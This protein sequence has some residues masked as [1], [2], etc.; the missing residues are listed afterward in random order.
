M[1]NPTTPHHVFCLFLSLMLTV[2]VPL[3]G[4]TDSLVFKNGDVMVGELK[5]M[6]RGVAIVST[7]YSDTDFK[8]SWLEV[9]RVHAKKS[10]VVTTSDDRQYFG[11][12]HS[13]SDGKVSVRT[14]QGDTVESTIDNVV[15]L[16]PVEGTF[17]EKLSATI[18]VGFSLTKA[19]DLRQFTVGGAI[20][21]NEQKWSTDIV[22][23]FLNSTQDNVD[24]IRRNEGTLNY[25]NNL[26][27]TWYAMATLSALTNTEQKLD[28]RFSTQLVGARYLMRTN[29]GY[30]GVKA[31]VSRNFEKYS[32]ATGDRNTWEGVLGA[33]LNLYNAGDLSLVTTAASYPSFTESGRWRVDISCDG[34]YDLPLD[35]YIK[36]GV[37]FN[38]DNRPAAGASQSDYV[39]QTGFG[40]EW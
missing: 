9:R 31:G 34:K 11:I 20:G 25:R 24:P 19:N 38:Y 17:L 28:L 1:N 4:Q 8:I 26:T 6:D 40:W 16:N 3:F 12:L 35:F 32:S 29:S 22:L 27:N 15:Y 36:L 13:K 39:F 10:Y 30:L 14:A 33:E 2:A 7:N 23:N 5:S 18:D 21:Y 37:S